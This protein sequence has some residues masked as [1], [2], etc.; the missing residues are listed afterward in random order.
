MQCQLSIDMILGTS[1][2]LFEVIKPVSAVILS[3]IK[4][5]LFNIN[6]KKIMKNIFILLVALF[7]IYSNFNVVCSL[8][9]SGWQYVCLGGAKSAHAMV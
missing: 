1:K 9:D 6:S 7:N 2:M 3:T 5:T 8:I 4:L